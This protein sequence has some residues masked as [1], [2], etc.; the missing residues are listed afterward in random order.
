[1]PPRSQVGV[2]LG[3]VPYELAADH[4]N[5]PCC[6]L[7]RRRTLYTSCLAASEVS[8][9]LESRISGTSVAGNVEETGRVLSRWPCC[10]RRTILLTPDLKV[11]VT[12]SVVSG[13]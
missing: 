12:V 10:A 6:V 4:A 3:F 2:L 5:Y 7:S 8:S 13:V 11:L 1:M 9:I